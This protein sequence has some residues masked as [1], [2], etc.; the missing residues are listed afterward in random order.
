MNRI[1]IVH[2]ITKLELGGAQGN[3]LYT[4][5]HLDR[6]KFDVH[7]ITGK[8]G[9]LDIEASALPDVTVNFC[10]DLIREVRPW[11]DLKA[12]SHLK[13]RFDELR[14]DIV[15]T[16]SSNAGTLGRRAAADA[17]IPAIVHTYHGFGFHV[18]QNPAAFR[19]YV[20]AERAACRRTHHL[21][22]VSRDNWRFA[23]SLHLTN[24]CKAS[25]IRSGIPVKESR[26]AAA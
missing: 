2:V 8:G 23:E 13:T 12:Y 3:T 11:A 18:F 15:H 1:R 9:M 26:A 16:H 22:F 7:L 6:S 20:A 19:A 14:P 17:G 10:D 21:V 25:M 5:S 24:G 4:V